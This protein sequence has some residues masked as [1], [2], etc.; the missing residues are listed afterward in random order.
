MFVPKIIRMC[1]GANNHSPLQ[2]KEDQVM[3]RNTFVGRINSF[4][5]H[6]EPSPSPS[7]AKRAR[8]K[9]DPEFPR[10][11]RWKRERVRARYKSVFVSFVNFVV[12]CL[13]IWLTTGSGV[14]LA[15]SAGGSDPAAVNFEMHCATCHAPNGSG[16][17]AVGKSVK[18]PDLRSPAV[19]SQSDAQLAEIIA[20]GKGA[21]PP[22]K[23]NLS[24]DEIDA[25]V[26]HVHQLAKT[27]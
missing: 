20:N 13:L 3:N 5:P 26:K 17:T 27:K 22:F 4:L 25:L 12:S 23:S 24:T 16:D 1:V 7:P 21:M 10:P 18:I 15:A 6:T 14:A 2:F 19:Q 8:V 9:R 11:F